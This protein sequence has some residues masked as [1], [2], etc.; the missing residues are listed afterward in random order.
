MGMFLI[1]G[2]AAQPGGVPGVPVWDVPGVPALTGIN[3]SP[4][5]SSSLSAPSAS[6]LIFPK[7][8][9]CAVLSREE[10]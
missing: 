1:S 2:V 8:S 9:I 10:H 5:L 7:L 6:Q 3:A 4:E